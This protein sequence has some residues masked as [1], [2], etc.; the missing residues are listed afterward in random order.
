[1][2]W[3]QVCAQAQW[4]GRQG[5]ACVNIGGNIVVM[6]GFGGA[7]RFNDMWKSNDGGK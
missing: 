6:G 4:E 1:M 3:N 5:Q 7:T 2:T